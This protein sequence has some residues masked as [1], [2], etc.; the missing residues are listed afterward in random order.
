MPNKNSYIR[1]NFKMISLFLPV[2]A[3]CIIII[4]PKLKEDKTSKI[5]LNRK[6]K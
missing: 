5:H 4:R 1:G 2:Y 3:D 6:G